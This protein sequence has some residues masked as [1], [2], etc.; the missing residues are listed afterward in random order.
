MK[1]LLLGAIETVPLVAVPISGMFVTPELSPL[2]L[3]AFGLGGSL[4]LCWLLH[5]HTPQLPIHAADSEKHAA[6]ESVR[7]HSGH[8]A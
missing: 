7:S 8:Q 4:L 3:L 2:S 1:M 6:E 5:N